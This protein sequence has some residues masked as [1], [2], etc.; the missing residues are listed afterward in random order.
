M[1]ASLGPD[2]HEQT[3]LGS[4]SCLPSFLGMFLRGSFTFASR[5]FSSRGD[6][7]LPEREQKQGDTGSLHTGL[8]R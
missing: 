3:F 2:I 1:D 7:V 4:T 6:E 8:S 5:N